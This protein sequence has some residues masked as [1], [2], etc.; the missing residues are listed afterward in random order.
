MKDENISS[1][2]DNVVNENSQSIPEPACVV[3]TT[4]SGK[5]ESIFFKFKI[6]E[7]KCD[8]EEVSLTGA[9]VAVTKTFLSN[10]ED[11]VDVEIGTVNDS[12]TNHTNEGSIIILDSKQMYDTLT[13]FC[14]EGRSPNDKVYFSILNQAI[15]SDGEYQLFIPAKNIESYE[16]PKSLFGK[17]ISPTM[18]GYWP[19]VNAVMKFMMT[20]YDRL[21]KEYVQDRVTRS[22]DL[23]TIRTIVKRKSS[24]FTES[25]VIRESSKYGAKLSQE[26]ITKGRSTKYGL[27]ERIKF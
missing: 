18:Y 19:P 24:P 14:T 15:N 7:Y 20:K 11:I 3:N 5:S 23:M 12:I 13:P 9:R 25:D 2:T 26:K 4:R 10:S 8:H 17:T 22:S 6:P 1:L 27:V 16:L 21:H